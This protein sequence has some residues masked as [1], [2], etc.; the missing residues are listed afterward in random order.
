MDFFSWRQET[1]PTMVTHSSRNVDGKIVLEEQ[2]KVLRYEPL[3]VSR[4][5][6]TARSILRPRSY[7]IRSCRYK[8]GFI[9]CEIDQQF[10][11]QYP[12]YTY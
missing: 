11:I 8:T 7:P 6:R 10:P 3:D 1:K 9:L 4:T 2:G 12:K 5:D